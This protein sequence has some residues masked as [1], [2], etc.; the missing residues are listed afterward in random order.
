MNVLTSVAVRGATRIAKAMTSGAGGNSH[1]GATGRPAGKT[2]SHCS[3]V[4]QFFGSSS[5][6]V[7]RSFAST[8]KGPAGNKLA[9]KTSAVFFHAHR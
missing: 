7:R 8:M 5:C 3:R 6:C 1:P 9:S 2:L 4:G